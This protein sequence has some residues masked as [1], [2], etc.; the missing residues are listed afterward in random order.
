MATWEEAVQFGVPRQRETERLEFVMAVHK[1]LLRVVQHEPVD[2]V[3]P[4]W[5]TELMRV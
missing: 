1:M 2:L 4:L 3:F 5:D